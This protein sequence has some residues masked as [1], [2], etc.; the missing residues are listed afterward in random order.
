MINVMVTRRS[1]D[2]QW[3]WKVLKDLVHVLLVT[4]ALVPRKG[5]AVVLRCLLMLKA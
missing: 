1:L 4:G 3:R 5:G 2:I